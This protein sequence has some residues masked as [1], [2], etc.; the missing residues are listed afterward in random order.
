ML[1]SGAKKLE[2]LAGFSICLTF[3]TNVKTHKRINYIILT[4][5]NNLLSVQNVA[6]PKDV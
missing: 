6:K 1:V 3:D 5:P 4:H 2:K